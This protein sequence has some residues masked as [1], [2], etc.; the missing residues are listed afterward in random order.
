MV[1]MKME[2]VTIVKQQVYRIM[3]SMKIDCFNDLDEVCPVI[4]KCETNT[5]NHLRIQ[6][7][8]MDRFR[9]YRCSS[10]VDCPFLVRLSRRQSDRK[11]VISKMNGKHSNVCRPSWAT[12]G[13][14]LIKCRQGKLGE[15]LLKVLQT[16]EGIPVP[17]N[18]TKTAI[19]KEYNEDL[20][21]MVAWRAINEDT[22]RKK[23]YGVMKFQLIIPYLDEMRKCNLLSVIGYTRGVSGCDLIDD[24]FFPY[25][26]NDALKS[27]RPVILLDAA[28]LCSEYIGMLYIASVLSGGDVIYSIDF[29]IST[30]NEDRKMWTK[31]SDKPVPSYLNKALVDQWFKKAMWK[32]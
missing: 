29:M 4:E 18:I 13:R 6:Q 12:D 7:S 31:I 9:V 27:V 10:H 17:R 15:I 30:G 3:H 8:V 21:Y 16:K 20:P 24:Q 28:H 22:I 26:E 1:T 5:G 23:K 25:I 14:H 32:R 19:Q 11:Y 2:L